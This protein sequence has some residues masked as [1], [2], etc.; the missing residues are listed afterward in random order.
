M[1]SKVKYLC[2]RGLWFWHLQVGD[3]VVL[4]STVGCRFKPEAEKQWERTKVMLEKG[5]MKCQS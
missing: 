2:E 5:M 1:K 4:S 3:R